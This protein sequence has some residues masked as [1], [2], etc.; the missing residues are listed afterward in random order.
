VFLENIVSGPHDVFCRRVGF[1]PAVQRFN[2]QAPD[3]VRQAFTLRRIVTLDSVNVTASSAPRDVMMESFAEHKTRGFG[4]F[5]DRKD[6]E[7]QEGRTLAGVLAQTQGLGIIYG[8][9]NQG[10]VVGRRAPMA[11]RCPANLP[12]PSNPQADPKAKACF[13]AEGWYLPEYDE[14]RAGVRLACYAKVYMDHVLMNPF[15]D[16]FDLNTVPVSQIEAMEWFTSNA[17]TPIEYMTRQARCGVLVIHTR[18]HF[19]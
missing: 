11:P 16:P 9:N 7:K 15:S 12:S 1:A 5:F 19:Q 13:A 6:L 2:F 10:W 8:S 18:R 3:T 14:V 4:S 17:Q